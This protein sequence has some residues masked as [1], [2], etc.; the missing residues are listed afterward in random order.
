MSAMN[1]EL[2]SLTQRMSQLEA[3]VEAL[4][5][6]LAELRSQAAT[7]PAR[8]A[9]PPRPEET[10]VRPLP[11]AGFRPLRPKEADESTVSPKTK[12]EPAFNMEQTL[13]I[14]LPRVFMFI[15]L[16]G[17][18]WGLKVGMD[19]G[20]ITNPIRVV[21][22][23][24]GTGLLYYLGMRFIQ[25]GKKKYGLTLLGGFLALGILTTFAAHHL[26]GYFSFSVAFIVGVAY[27]VAGLWLSKKMRSE[28]LTIFSAIAGFLLPFL[29]EGEGATAVQFCLYILLLF[30]SLFYVSLSQKHK[31][32]FYVTFLLFHLTLLVYGILDG[33]YGDETILVGTALIQHLALLFFYVRGRVARHVFTEALLYTNFVFSI[34]WVKLLSDS[35]ET[36]VYGL[37]ALLY[38]VLAGVMYGK[39]DRLLQGVL[40][41][42]AVFAVSVFILSFHI[43]QYPVRLLLLL[44]NGAIGVWIG[45][46]F[47]TFRTVVTG[48]AVYSWV[49]LTIL[50]TMPI[51][52]LFSLEHFV[53]LLFI[54]SMLWI[55]GSLYR[56]P[57]ACL[58]GKV[59]RLDQSLVAGQLVFLFYL[60]QL[61]M[62]WIERSLISYET[63]THVQMLV[64]VGA[65]A[66]MYGFHKWKHGLYLTHAAVFGFLLMGLFVLSMELSHSFDDLGFFFNVA[67]QMIYVFLLTWMIRAILNGTFYMKREALKLKVS[68]LAVVMQTLYFLFLNKWYFA[69]AETFNWGWEF[70]L[71]FHTF[72]LFAVAF[73]SISVGRK[74][75]WR[76]VKLLGVALIG[77][78]I[79]KLFFVDLASISI[80]IRAILFIVVGTVGLVYSR[81]LL[82]EQE[83]EKIED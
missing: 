15:L 77:L 37:L 13:G 81:T 19:Y 62:I 66:A 64:F 30:L 48:G 42:V 65:F 56:F 68:G 6:E 39:K 70:V 10:P 22:G 44:I 41:A 1:E 12:A 72:L 61:M 83:N 29:L 55:Y 24:G 49:A 73:L 74:M 54:G 20:V 40:S 14:W 51:R 80:L 78:C 82:K 50:G 45:L 27:I 63:A 47:R 43:D 53:W 67:V 18:L 38:I 34:G 8:Q 69:F 28:T 32:T 21:L 57:L 35:E 60:Y 46:R 16:L 4:K 2:D 76:Q 52:E 25:K 11:K 5:R 36:I 59:E 71:L 31:Y 79:L 3:E 58:K 23:Y 9:P 75:E 17:L 33:T 7:V 26:Y